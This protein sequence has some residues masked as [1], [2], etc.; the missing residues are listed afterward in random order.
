MK[1][2][3][4]YAILALFNIYFFSAAQTKISGTVYELNQNSKK[5]PLPGA[6]LHWLG[7]TNG[8]SSDAEGR[9]TLNRIEKVNKLVV[10]HVSYPADTLT[11]SESKDTILILLTGEKY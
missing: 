6:T 11:I 3:I 9:F 7:T 4:F 5:T 10:Q 2:K 8:V 1:T